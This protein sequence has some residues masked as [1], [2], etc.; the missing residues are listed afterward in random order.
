MAEL[1]DTQK[2]VLGPDAR[3]T[4]Q[5]AVHVCRFLEAGREFERAIPAWTALVADLGRVQGDHDPATLEARG[6]LVRL[7]CTTRG[8]REAA[9]ELRVLR[10][11]LARTGPA[12]LGRVVGIRMALI[13]CHAQAG[14]RETAAALA[15]EALRD[16]I[17]LHGADHPKTL[18][19]RAI[20]LSCGIY[21]PGEEQRAA[22]GELTE[23]LDRL[24]AAPG[25]DDK[26]LVSL[27]SRLAEMYADAG[28][29]VRALEITAAALPALEKAIGPE[30][31][32]V[33]RLR[34]HEAWWRFRSGDFAGAVSALRTLLDIESCAL[35]PDHESTLVTR[36]RLR[37][38][39][40]AR[41]GSRERRRSRRGCGST[42]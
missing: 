35:G 37:P 1:H 3:D 4:L 18:L 36:G 21:P 34:G 22:I 24:A 8:P 20:A 27:R 25:P 26:Q 40:C 15:Q 41:P 23:L 39:R 30:H 33:L 42:A 7:L 5:S 16:R 9:A 19:V 13:A 6:E 32:A 31:P 11:G 17:A 29:H 10:D 2:R 28:D 12:D 14:D 38:A